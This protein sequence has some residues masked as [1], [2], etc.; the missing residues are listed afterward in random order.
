[1]IG[2]PCEHRQ[3]PDGSVAPLA[4][5][6]SEVGLTAQLRA[7]AELFPGQDTQRPS[8]A[9]WERAQLLVGASMQRDWPPGTRLVWTA[10]TW[11]NR[12]SLRSQVRRHLMRIFYAP[13][14]RS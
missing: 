3:G 8:E 12:A 9:E 11:R 7:V 5:A 14:P 10:P 1:M 2:P 6:D 4:A 13:R